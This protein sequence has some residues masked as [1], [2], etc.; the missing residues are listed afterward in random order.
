MYDKQLEE[1]NDLNINID[2]ILIE[3]IKEEL[4]TLDLEA[5]TIQ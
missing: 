5:P 3:D 2:T 4:R 1:E